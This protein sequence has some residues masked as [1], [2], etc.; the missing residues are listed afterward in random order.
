M[1]GTIKWYSLDEGSHYHQNYMGMVRRIQ[2]SISLKQS[3]GRLCHI[4]NEGL[5]NMIQICNS[6]FWIH[7]EEKSF[8]SCTQPQGVALVNISKDSGQGTSVQYHRKVE[9]CNTLLNMCEDLVYSHS[10]F[11]VNVK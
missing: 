9:S 5:T 11:L 3:F 10:K 1:E 2:Q 4:C 6:E 8:C 7:S